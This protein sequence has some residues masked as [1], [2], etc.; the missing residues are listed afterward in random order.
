MPVY[1]LF[2]G[3]PFD[4]G[5]IELMSSVLEDVSSELRLAQREDPFRDMIAKAIIEC[6]KGA[7][8][9]RRR[10]E[11]ALMARLKRCEA[12]SYIS[13]AFQPLPTPFSKSLI[14]VPHIPRGVIRVRA[15]IPPDFGN[16]GVCH[17]MIGLKFQGCW[18]HASCCLGCI[19][20]FARMNSRSTRARVCPIRCAIYA[21]SLAENAND[22]SIS[23]NA[24]TFHGSASTPPLFG[25]MPLQPREE[26]DLTWLKIS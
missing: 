15:R 24:L 4:P 23:M 18:Q 25:V 2:R 12:D 1:P 20:K 13:S 19:S 10:C 7:S 17:A 22:W 9:T 8:A 21:R 3:L 16:L 5:Y 11:S 6:A 14:S 26:G